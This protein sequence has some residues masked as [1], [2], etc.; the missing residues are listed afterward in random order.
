MSGIPQWVEDMR[1]D[2]IKIKPEYSGN[3]CAEQMEKR[4]VFNYAW[5]LFTETAKT[6][7]E[8]AVEI[9]NYFDEYPDAVV[10]TETDMVNSDNALRELKAKLWRKDS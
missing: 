7:I 2:R 8:R 3:F 9:A 6:T 4:A 10:I 5:N 1:D